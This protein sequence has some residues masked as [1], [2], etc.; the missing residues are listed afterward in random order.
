MWESNLER[1]LVLW[2]WF[3]CCGM[4]SF[5]VASEAVLARRGW[6]PC[7]LP[8]SSWKRLFQTKIQPLASYLDDQ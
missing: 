8:C 3:C 1:F 6:Q 7:C 5:A 2:V 4:L